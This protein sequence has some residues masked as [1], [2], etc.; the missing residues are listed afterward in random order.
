[1]KTRAQVYYNNKLLYENYIGKRSHEFNIDFD[2]DSQYRICSN[3]KLFTSVSE[4]LSGAG[5]MCAGGHHA[6]G[7][8]RRHQ[9][10]A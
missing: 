1:M 7:G 5:M 2:A 10:R 6:T 4:L 8:G 3:T 9:Q